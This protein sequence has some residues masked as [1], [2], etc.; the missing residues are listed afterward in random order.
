M[1]PKETREDRIVIVPPDGIGIAREICGFLDPFTILS[2]VG[3]SWSR[4]AVTTSNVTFYSRVVPRG[5]NG[6]ETDFCVAS[7][8]KWIP[9]VR[10]ETDKQFAIGVGTL[11]EGSRH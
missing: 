9:E 6:F 8:R 11:Y 2:E 5:A 7:I 1:G 4:A 3:A 10:V